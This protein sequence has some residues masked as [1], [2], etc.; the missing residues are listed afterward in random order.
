MPRWVAALRFVGI[1][2]YIAL[3][4]AGGI[5]LGLWLDSKLNSTPLLAFV[6]LGFGILLAFVGVYNIL[7]PALYRSRD[8]KEDE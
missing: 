7:R 5:W 4:I 2:W 3:C 8:K 1:G 6:G